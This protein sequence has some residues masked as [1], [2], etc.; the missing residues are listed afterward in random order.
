MSNYLGQEKHDIQR[1]ARDIAD[2]IISSARKSGDDPIS[3]V[4]GNSYMPPMR[5]FA[6]AEKIW[7]SDAGNYGEL[8]ASLVELVESH[9]EEAHVYLACPDYDNAYYAVDMARFEYEESGTGE[10]LQDD[11]KAITP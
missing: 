2:G 7:Q 3:W 1:S 8:F 5:S 6:A 11:W 10:N 9:C 4:T